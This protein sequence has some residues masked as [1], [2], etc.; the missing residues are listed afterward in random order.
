M[1][2][3]YVNIKL[4]FFFILFRRRTI[5]QHH[6]PTQRNLDTLEKNHKEN[7]FV[8]DAQFEW[9]MVMENISIR[10]RQYFQI[11]NPGAKLRHCTAIWRKGLYIPK[12]SSFSLVSDSPTSVLC[13]SNFILEVH[14]HEWKFQ[15]REIIHFMSIQI[16]VYILLLQSHN[17]NVTVH[18]CLLVYIPFVS[19][20]HFSFES[21]GVQLR[22]RRFLGKSIT[23]AHVYP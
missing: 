16:Y 13:E 22:L 18:Q 5:P 3:L 2:W 6:H 23:P 15:F 10:W 20:G 17:R 7:V 1:F 21:A 9:I 8:F 14:A 11:P 12:S 19:R 4:R